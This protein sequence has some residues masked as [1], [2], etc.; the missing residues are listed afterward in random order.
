M[1]T[2]L[3][4][5]EAHVVYRERQPLRPQARAR[6]SSRP[7]A[8][9][10]LSVL[11]AAMSDLAC[12]T[13]H[14]PTATT[15]SAI[16]SEL[17]DI[18]DFRFT[19]E[20]IGPS[21][22]SARKA[23]VAQLMYAQG[24]L[25]TAKHGNGQIR[26]VKLTN[27]RETA[28]GEKRRITYD[29][30]MP[31]AWP[32]GLAA[33]SSYELTLP[34]D[35]T[36]L[37]SF[38]E[39]YDGRCGRIQHGKHTFWHDFNPKARRCAFDDTDVSRAVVTVAPH[40]GETENKYPEYDLLWADDRL[41]VVAIFG[42][43]ESKKKPDD[44]GFSEA[45]KFVQN[46]K[47]QL[48]DARAN[49]NE[50]SESILVHT[51]VNG[52]A[53]VRGRLRDVNVD[54]FVVNKIERTGEDFDARYDALS[55]TADMIMYNGHTD[56]GEGLDALSRKGNVTAG[57]YQ[58]VLLNGCQSF[59]LMDETMTERRR[60]ANG[61]DDPNGTKFLDVVTNALPGYADTLA[62]VSSSVLAAA[63]GVDAPKNYNELLSTMPEANIAVV[64]GEEDNRFSP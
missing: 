16:T 56:S 19:G 28:A 64:F 51:T 33:P 18:L 11:V 20:V 22:G 21:G 10:L 50:P 63:I 13:E 15:E 7:W 24:I 46:T 2:L 39:K 3:P 26:N 37:D 12:S 48:V 41:D 59:A 52:K 29:A 35:V 60:A 38:D 4:K 61:D 34:L 5:Y 62:S 27:V 49:D 57:H 43:I 32:Q 23:I 53:K 45:Q 58:L 8:R 54:V 17:A 36:S 42:I 9:A 30:S 55:E 14:T 25:T 44:Y 31:V 1:S 47:G 6:G 40:Q